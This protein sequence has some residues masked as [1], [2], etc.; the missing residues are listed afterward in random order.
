MLNLLISFLALGNIILSSA[1]IVVASSL[2][3]YLLANS[4]HNSVARSFSGLLAFLTII[5]IG[6]VFLQRVD[7][8]ADPTNAI[9]WLK[10]KW[11]G[12]A[13]IP[14]TYM[15]FSDAL[16]RSTNAYSRRRRLAVVLSYLSSG[17]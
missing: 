4:F 11:I 15:H 14:A 6:D 12:I 5:Y 3:L 17:I 8:V 1:L 9:L 13:F 10:F 7:T 16:L 2:F